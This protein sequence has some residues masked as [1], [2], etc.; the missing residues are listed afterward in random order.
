MNVKIFFGSL[1]IL[2]MVV[3]GTPAVTQEAKYAV[4]NDFLGGRAGTAYPG[5]SFFICQQNKC[6]RGATNLRVG[7]TRNCLIFNHEGTYKV[8]CGNFWVEPEVVEE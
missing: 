1:I 2:A 4:N 3:V 5:E 6:F 8:V 7:P